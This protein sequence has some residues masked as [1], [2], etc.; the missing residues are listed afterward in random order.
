MKSNISSIF[1]NNNRRYMESKIGE[2]LSFSLGGSI[3]FL[4]LLAKE[5]KK[6]QREKKKKKKKK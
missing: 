5:K 6:I 4:A 1:K 2:Y 3:V